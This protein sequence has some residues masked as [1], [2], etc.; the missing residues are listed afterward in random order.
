MSLWGFYDIQLQNRGISRSLIGAL[1]SQNV[2]YVRTWGKRNIPVPCEC[3][4]LEYS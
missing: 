1:G 4:R 2:N 3:L